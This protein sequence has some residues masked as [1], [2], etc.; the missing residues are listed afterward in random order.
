MSRKRI[1]FEDVPLKQRYVEVISPE[2]FLFADNSEIRWPKAS[3]V[4]EIKLATALYKGDDRIVAFRRFVYDPEKG[5]KY[6]DKGWMYFRGVV[7]KGRDVVDG[8]VDCPV[9]DIARQNIE[10]NHFEK[11]IYFPGMYRMYWFTKQDKRLNLDKES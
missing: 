1:N 4:D 11:V 6:F 2:G 7:Y 9:G 5:K 8:K 3:W 10:C